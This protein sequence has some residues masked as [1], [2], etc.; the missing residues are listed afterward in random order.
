M[1]QMPEQCKDHAAV[2][3]GRNGIAPGNGGSD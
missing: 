3:D 1:N 2:V